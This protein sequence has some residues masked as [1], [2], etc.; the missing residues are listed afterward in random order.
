[1]LSHPDYSMLPYCISSHNNNTLLFNFVRMHKV[2]LVEINDAVVVSGD[3]DDGDGDGGGKGSGGK[4]TKNYYDDDD[5]DD[6]DSNEYDG[7]GNKWMMFTVIIAV[8]LE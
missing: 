2:N 4:I 5:N 6:D 8:W 3:S 7:G 1:M